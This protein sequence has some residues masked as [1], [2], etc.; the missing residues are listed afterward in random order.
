MTDLQKEFEGTGYTS[1]VNSDLYPDGKIYTQEYTHWLEKQVLAL[2]QQNVS[3]KVCT[4]CGWRSDKKIDSKTAL[5]CCPDN[6]YVELGEYLKNSVYKSKMETEEHFNVSSADVKQKKAKVLFS[7]T[8]R[9]GTVI[10]FSN[11]KIHR[12][13]YE[14]DFYLEEEIIKE[15]RK[16][17]TNGSVYD[18]G[19][20]VGAIFIDL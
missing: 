4:G 10:G 14:D 7:I 20:F 13:I 9:R 6:N 15:K 8:A 16:E 12:I 11:P 17:L 1:W 18:Y 3:I 2:R 5:A 19:L